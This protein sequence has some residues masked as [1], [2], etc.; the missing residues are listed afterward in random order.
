MLLIKEIEASISRKRNINGIL[1]LTVQQH[2]LLTLLVSNDFLVNGRYI[3]LR[4][5]I[6]GWL[7]I[8]DPV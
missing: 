5:L 2:S 4:R 6:Q 7:I 3:I 1:S 8:D